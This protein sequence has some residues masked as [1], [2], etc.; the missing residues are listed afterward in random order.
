MR[1]TPKRVYVGMATRQTGPLSITSHSCK[2]LNNLGPKAFG[3][4]TSRI[5]VRSPKKSPLV[6][7]LPFARFSTFLKLLM[8]GSSFS[9]AA[10][11]SLPVHSD[12]EGEYLHRFPGVTEVC[13]PK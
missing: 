13:K 12:S 11:N 7:K 3:S 8:I 6:Y 9:S 1:T 4:T 10:S 5:C 2:A